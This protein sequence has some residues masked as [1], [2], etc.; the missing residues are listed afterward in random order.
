MYSDMSDS[1][2]K[3]KIRH[4]IDENLK[5][6]YDETLNEQIPDKLTQLLEQLRRKAGDADDGGA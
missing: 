1:N 2:P 3:S 4:Q 5:R 6:I